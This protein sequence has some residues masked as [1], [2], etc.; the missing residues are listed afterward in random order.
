M[1]TVINYVQHFTSVST[2]TLPAIVADRNRPEGVSLAAL[3]GVAAIHSGALL[4]LAR[5]APT[6]PPVLTPA[7]VSLQVEMVPLAPPAT[8]HA[9]AT[10]APSDPIKQETRPRMK[11]PVASPPVPSAKA[12]ET[13]A[14]PSE[15]AAADAPTATVQERP[16]MATEAS[17]A[18]APAPTEITQARF[19]ANYLK[20]P[21]PAYPVMSRRLGEEGRVV[22]R[23]FVSAE[24]RPEQIELKNSSGFP[25]LDQAAEEAVRRWKFAP[26][27]RGD[28]AVATWV[29][30][31]IVF[32][33]RS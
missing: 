17:A 3:I 32:N 20:N 16:A 4:C 9:P 7:A 30:V 26:A 19:D 18:A 27:R 25:R 8:T 15:L 2:H 29:A 24:G 22:L 6:R 13:I 31:P 10:I 5:F 23:V 12:S 11:R 21:A 14:A 33:L 1:R 28:E